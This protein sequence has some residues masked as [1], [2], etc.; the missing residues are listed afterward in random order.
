VFTDEYVFSCF[1]AFQIPGQLSGG[2][3]INKLLY[4]LVFLSQPFVT[5][6]TIIVGLL[7]HLLRFR[8]S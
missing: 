3:W 7:K 6:I 1:V 2:T 8:L 5:E 4:D